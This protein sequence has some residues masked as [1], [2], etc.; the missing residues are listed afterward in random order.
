M[1][2][3]IDVGGGERGIYGAG[4]FD[5]C[6]DLGI[7][8]DYLIGVSAGSA[9]IAAFLGGQRGRN[10]RFYTEYSFRPQYMSVRNML[11]TGS[12][13]NLEYVYGTLSNHDGEAPLNYDGIVESGKPFYIVATNAMTG[14]P[15][16]FSSKDMKQDDYGPIKASSAVPVASKPWVIDNVPYFDGAISDPIPLKKAFDDGCDKV[17]L[18]LTRPKDYYR[19]SKDDAKNAKRIQKK[20]PGSA[21]ALASRA[22][23]YNRELDFAHEKEREGKVL[24]VAPDSIG[25]MGTLTK[26]KDEIREMYS[27]GLK[28]AWAIKDFMK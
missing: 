28:D 9:N 12:F 16:Y 7:T 3:V 14:Q 18:I 6:L 4:V 21:K 13:L 23:V 1:I 11:K 22:E 10:Y 26:D 27:K 5:R 17:V 15:H 24:I 25:N 19:S 8:F 20:Y 2:G